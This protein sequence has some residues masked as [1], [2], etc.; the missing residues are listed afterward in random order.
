MPK[1]TTKSTKRRI[2]PIT[3]EDA[4]LIYRNFSG[5]A[6]TYNAKGLRNF[7]VVLDPDVA[8]M[9]QR[10]GWN[11]KWDQP[12]EEG[13]PPRARLKVSVRFDNYPPRITLITKRGKALLDEESVDILDSAD[14]EKVD[15]VVTASTGEMTT[16]DRK[17]ESY[18]KAYLSKMFVVLSDT[19][20]ESK[21][22]DVNSTKNIVPEDDD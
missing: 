7:N 18:V 15:M 19:D 6:K 2:P 22:A 17:G 11:I 8:E 5:A 14:I 12:R 13:D 20:L 9:L 16:G 4:H 10:D 21:Y 3:I 1:Q